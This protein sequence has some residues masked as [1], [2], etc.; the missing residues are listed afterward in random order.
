MKM[1]CKDRPEVSKGH[2]AAAEGFGKM[3][4]VEDCFYL[5]WSH[6]FFP[7]SCLY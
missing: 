3:E 4:M 1:N 2:G 7:I 6:S 5:F